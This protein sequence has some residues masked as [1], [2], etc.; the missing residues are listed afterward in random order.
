M[1]LIAACNYYKL[2][3]VTDFRNHARPKNL[4]ATRSVLKILCIE[5]IALPQ[6]D[7]FSN[8]FAL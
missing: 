8:E 4:F 3:E 7:L 5:N 6:K 2:E 1:N